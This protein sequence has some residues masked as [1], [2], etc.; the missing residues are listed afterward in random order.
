MADYH[1]YTLGRSQ[2]ERRLNRMLDQRFSAG[3]VQ[4]F[5]LAGLHARPQP[6]GQNRNRHSSI[7][8]LYYSLL[9]S[10]AAIFFRRFLPSMA[11][12]MAMAAMD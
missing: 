5:G 4:H 1:E 3:L 8:V 12:R 11:K 2:L 6:G 10:T 9:G 7:H